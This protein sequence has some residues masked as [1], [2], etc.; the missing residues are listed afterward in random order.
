[1]CKYYLVIFSVVFS[2]LM[3]AQTQTDA[4]GKKQGYWRKKDEK[5]KKLVYE[6]LFKDDKPQGKFKYYYPHLIVSKL[7]WILRQDGK[8]CILNHVSSN[9]AKKMA[10]GKYIGEDKDSVWTY[11]DDKAV[12][13]SRETYCKWTKRMEWSMFIFLMEL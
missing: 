5:S 11:Y 4:N 6:G 3:H 8:I 2:F 9:M 7:L 13:I 10:Y 12:L 1:M